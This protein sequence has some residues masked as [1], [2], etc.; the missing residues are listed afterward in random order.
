MRLFPVGLIVWGLVSALSLFAAERQV[1][2]ERFQFA[3]GGTVSVENVYGNIAVE[4]WDRAEVQVLVIKRARTNN[5]VDLDNVR[6]AVEPGTSA[7]AFRTLY[8]E[9]PEQ[10]VTVDY[11]IRVPRQTH[12]RW[13]NTVEGRITVRDVEGDVHA[14]TLNGNIE[15]L[16]VSGH[17]VAR[18]MNGNISVVMWALVRSSEPH[19]LETL[20]GDI[21]LLLPPNP[22]ADL[23]V[24]SVAGRVHTPY[25]LATRTGSPVG[26]F[27]ARVGKGGNV[28]QLRAVRGNIRVQEMEPLL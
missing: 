12:L 7:L 18:T 23:Q 19:E 13:L 14:R 16:N 26:T 21:A 24:Q 11:R 27:Q 28:I 10:P 17:V 3:P 25:T 9:Q 8:A 6:V 15:H 1:W 4:G 20:T 22:D 5:D 2:V